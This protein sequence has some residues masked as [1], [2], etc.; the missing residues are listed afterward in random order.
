MP[1]LNP[2]RN[3]LI[4][5][6]VLG[7]PVLFILTKG[8]KER[9]RERSEQRQNRWMGPARTQGWVPQ[10][11]VSLAPSLT[12]IL[13]LLGAQAR[14]KGVT[15][16]CDWP[17]AARRLPQVGG[18]IDPNLEAVMALKPDLVIAQP[19]SGN[20]KVVK[21]LARM[22]IRIILV[23]LYSIAD[24]W[25]SI[26]QLGIILK[27]K[28]EA[29]LLMRGIKARMARVTVRLK[30]ARRTKVL[31]IYGTKPLVAAGQGTFGNELIRLA[32]GLN[33][34]S[35][36]KLRYPIFSL[37]RIL[38]LKPEVILSATMSP[39]GDSSLASVKRYWSRWP[40]LPAVKKGAIRWISPSLIARPGPRIDRTIEKMA[41]AI[42]PE[43]FGLRK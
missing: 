4:L 12:E 18:Y 34:A 10:R 3:T 26:R 25:A 31:L 14:L 39:S 30:G 27:K 8:C 38:A 23:R 20:R 21:N 24:I 6:L 37:E 33:I 29:R 36:S 11:I 32:G 42:H 19:N 13:F 15:R 2:L 40:S 5:L 17:P 1:R 7:L 41:K 35:E 22:G 43:R 9:G 28:K 16:F